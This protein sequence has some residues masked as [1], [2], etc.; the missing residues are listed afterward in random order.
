M[1]ENLAMKY[2]RNLLRNFFKRFWPFI[3]IFFIVAVF[4]YPVWFKHLVPLPAD[5]IVGT[6]FPWLDYK[7]GYEVGVPVK[8]ALTSDVVSI[9]YPLR[10][11]AVESFTKGKLTLWNSSMFTGYPLIA[12]FQVAMF[13]PTM[14]FYLVLSGLKGWTAQIIF[15][16]LA[17]GVSSYV[18]FRH[19]KLSKE[20]SLFG[21][22]VYSFAGFNIIWLLWNVHSLVASFIPLIILFTDKYLLGGKIKWLACLSLAVG[23]QILSGYPQVVLYTSIFVLIFIPF[24]GEKVSFKKLLLL[25]TFGLLGVALASIQLFPGIELFLKSQRVVESLDPNLVFLPLQKLITFLIPDYFG[26][27]ATGNYWGPG[28]YTLNTIYSGIIPFSLALVG[29]LYSRKNKISQYF[30]ILLIIPLFLATPNPVSTFLAKSNLLGLAAASPTRLFIF[31]NLSIAFLSA[32]GV[33]R[34]INKKNINYRL[35]YIPVVFILSTALGTYL[36]SRL[37]PPD[38]PYFLYLRIALRNIA[39]PFFFLSSFLAIY[40]FSK[41]LYRKNSFKPFIFWLVFVLTLLELYRFA[42]KFTPFSSP[43]LVF[44]QTPVISYLEKQGKPLRFSPGDVI[45]MNMWVPYGLESVSGYDVVYPSTWAKLFYAITSNKSKGAYQGRYAN[46]EEYN[47]AWFDFL[48][49]KY[50]LALKKEIDGKPGPGGKVSYSF[51]TPKFEK[52]FEDKSVVVLANKSA[53]ERAMMFYDWDVLIDENE[54]MATLI[55]KEFDLDQKLILE[56]DPSIKRSDRGFSTIKY[57]YYSSDRSVIQI[58]TDKDG[59]LFVSDTYYPG[60]NVYVDGEK[61]KIYKADY[62]FRAVPLTA[63]SHKV[64]FIYEPESFK[65]GK[66]TSIFTFLI[67]LVI[68]VNEQFGK[69]GSRTSRTGPA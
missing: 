36:S 22:L 51:N 20:S 48:N 66:W 41:R 6:Y 34:L 69:I 46:F 29:Y 17:A 35:F 44:P 2:L 38:S 47:S 23:L 64:E 62:A 10:N 32:V 24:R 43:Q 40:L 21:S 25:S 4:F 5:F 57:D 26:N 42:W 12:N 52:V 39:L 11:L 16:L 18:L 28:N 7:W 14:I 49:N 55:D 13:A 8:N 58:D 31:V 27:P 9:V 60:W 45:P 59:M 50:V 68:L 15:Q 54:I 53:K 33:E 63:G 30:L 61:G 56:T 3:F 67:L 37:I 65:I 1:R 19:L